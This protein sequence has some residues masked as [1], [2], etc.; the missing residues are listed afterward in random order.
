TTL[1]T[2]RSGEFP[3]HPRCHMF[4]RASQVRPAG[5]P[6]WVRPWLEQLEERCAPHTGVTLFSN[7]IVPNA[8]LT[9][10]VQGPDDNFWFTEFNADRIGRT[11]R[12]G[13]ITEFTLPAGR[14][15]LN[16]IRGPDNRL[17]WFTS[18]N[19]DRIGR[20]DPLAGGDAAVQASLTEFVVPGAGSAP[21][22]I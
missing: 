2:H 7:G 8:G 14:G 15:P 3:L 19:G 5:P 12:A 21:H 20:L 10:I 13:V 9:G 22:D 4:R 18:S 1:T 17:L 11:T 6:R 16:I